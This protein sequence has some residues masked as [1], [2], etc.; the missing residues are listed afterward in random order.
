MRD[1]NLPN[2]PTLI[3]DPE[4]RAPTTRQHIE[5]ARRRQIPSR[6]D[7]GVDGVPYRSH[8]IGACFCCFDALECMR[9]DHMRGVEVEV[10]PGP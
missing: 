8:S 10:G 3:N 4:R 9:Q 2:N 6:L 7:V 5:G 1:L